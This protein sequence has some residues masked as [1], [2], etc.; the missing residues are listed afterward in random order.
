MTTS[1]SDAQRAAVSREIAPK[2][3]KNPALLSLARRALRKNQHRADPIED[4]IVGRGATTRLPEGGPSA[5][6]QQARRRG[7]GYLHGRM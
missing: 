6:F 3:K 7:R 2:E 5:A 4:P 1:S